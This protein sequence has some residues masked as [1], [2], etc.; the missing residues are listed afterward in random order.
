MDLTELIPKAEAL[1]SKQAGASVRLR[2]AWIAPRKHTSIVARVEQISGDTGLPRTLILKAETPDGSGD[3]ERML[4]NE[5]A[6]LQYFG[7]LGCAPP[8]AP[9]FY[10]GSSTG[11]TPFIVMEDLGPG[12]GSPGDVLEGDDL[13]AAAAAILDYAAALGRLHACGCRNPEGFRELRAE[14][15]APPLRIPLFHNPW[16]DARSYSHDEVRRAI[17]EYRASM[18]HLGVRRSFS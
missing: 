9:R 10:A 6:A 3:P 12:A 13:E 16:S 17:E 14:L 4:F 7:D 5:W 1:L 11:E 2:V 18:S 8:V 15:P